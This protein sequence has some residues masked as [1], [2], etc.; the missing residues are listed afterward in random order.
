MEN[1]QEIFNKIKKVL[2]KYNKY[3]TET[4]DTDGSYSLVS[5]KEIEILGRKRS[6]IAFASLIIQKNYVAFYYMPVYAFPNKASELVPEELLKFKNGK[7]CFTIT[8]INRALLKQ[9]DVA[10]QQGRDLYEDMNW[11]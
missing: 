11:V 10:L 2:K 7:S 6:D 9:I 8:K 5:I 3:F 4:L 1:K